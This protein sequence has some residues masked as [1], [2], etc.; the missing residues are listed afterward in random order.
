MHFWEEPDETLNGTTGYRWFQSDNFN[1]NPCT[2]LVNMSGGTIFATKLVGQ[3]LA[4]FV[5]DKFSVAML[6]KLARFVYV[7]QY[8]ELSLLCNIENTVF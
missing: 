4:Y 7:D 1:G 8:V 3:M 6:P 5:T 2:F